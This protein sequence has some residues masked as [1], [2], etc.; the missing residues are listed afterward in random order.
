MRRPFL[1][2]VPLLLGCTA[3]PARGQSCV[4][5]PELPRAELASALKRGGF[6]GVLD[7]SASVRL[8]GCLRGAGEELSVYYY[9]RAWGSARHMTA[10][11]VVVSNVAGYL[12]MYAVSGPPSAVHAGRIVFPGPEKDG[13]V[14]ALHDGRPPRNVL[15]DGEPLGFF[16]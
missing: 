14:I 9:E 5:S 1:L 6:S 7:D 8:A 3:L 11:L 15:I 10:R 4:A 16:R 12:G 2:L 13:N